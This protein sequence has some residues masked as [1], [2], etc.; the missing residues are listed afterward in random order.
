MVSTAYSS[1]TV[2]HKF[3]QWL[4]CLSINACYVLRREAGTQIVCIRSDADMEEAWK[5]VND[6]RLTLWM[7]EEKVSKRNGFIQTNN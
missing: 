1:S 5:S 6:G 3:H 2:R 4:D 7:F